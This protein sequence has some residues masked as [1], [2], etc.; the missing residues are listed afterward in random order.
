MVPAFSSNPNVF[1]LRVK[2]DGWF[3]VIDDGMYVVISPGDAPRQGEKVV[4]TYA[5]GRLT[6]KRLLFERADSIVVAPLQGGSQQTI[7][8]AQI[9]AIDPVIGVL[10]AS[11]WRP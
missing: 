2:G 5:D 1:A 7:E 10:E 3:P 6:I 9:A 8:R 11:S 4:V